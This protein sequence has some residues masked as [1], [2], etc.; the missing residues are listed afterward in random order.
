ML[1]VNIPKYFSLTASVLA[2]LRALFGDFDIDEIDDNSD[3]IGN[4]IL[5]MCYLFVAVFILLSM[6]LAILGEAQSQVLSV[7]EDTAGW[8]SAWGIVGESAK[9]IKSAFKMVI[10]R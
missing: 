4:S 6:F 7:S 3:D 2:M 1:G 9:A 8:P 10:N 5:F